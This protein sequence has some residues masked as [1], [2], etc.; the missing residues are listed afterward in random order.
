MWNWLNEF[1][2]KLL[3]SVLIVFFSCVWIAVR[4]VAMSQIALTLV[5]ALIGIIRGQFKNSGAN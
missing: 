4:D 2:D 3:L 1:D 5:G